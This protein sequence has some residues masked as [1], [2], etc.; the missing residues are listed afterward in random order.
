MP[1]FNCCLRFIGSGLLLIGM[2]LPAV[3][4]S[5]VAT[6]AGLRFSQASADF[7][8][9]KDDTGTG[10]GVV[11]G[12]SY[13][14]FRVVA[15]LNLYSWDEVNTRTI[16][17]SYERLWQVSG[18]WQAFAGVFGGV[19]DLELGSALRGKDDYQSGLSGGVQ[20]G[21]LYPLGRGWQLETGVRYNH[22][23]VE[24]SS[25]ALDEDVR[26]NSQVEV[27]VVLNFSS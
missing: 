13:P 3:A 5:D 1:R 19:V 6:L 14:T 2:A 21:V 24:I 22:F 17:A 27:F 23:S 16:H 9:I 7:S 8:G 18:D 11:L 10:V 25:P 12:V 15:D 20:A 4:A 26:L